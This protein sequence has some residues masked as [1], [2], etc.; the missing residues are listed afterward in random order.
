MVVT[1][2]APEAESKDDTPR[3][4]P[5][6][7]ATKTARRA[8]HNATREEDGTED[9]TDAEGKAH[10][11]GDERRQDLA[12]KVGRVPYGKVALDADE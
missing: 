10:A 2:R 4:P 11:V 5:D 12:G 7:P 3:R 9:G 6:E 1:D 8:K